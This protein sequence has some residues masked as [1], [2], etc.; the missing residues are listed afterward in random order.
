[1]VGDLQRIKIYP[2]KGFQVFQEIPYD[3]WNAYN[4]LIEFGFNKYLIK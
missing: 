1:M 4:Q 3:V 2:N